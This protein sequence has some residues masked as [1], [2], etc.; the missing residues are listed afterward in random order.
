MAGIKLWRFNNNIICQEQLKLTHERWVVF[1]FELEFKQLISLPIY[2]WL[3]LFALKY[4]PTCMQSN[5]G[6]FLPEV[7]SHPCYK[8]SLLVRYCAVLFNL[9]SP[10]LT[11]R[12]C[13]N[14]TLNYLPSFKGNVNFCFYGTLTGYFALSIFIWNKS[15]VMDKTW[16]FR[17]DLGL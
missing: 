15:K 9:S 4:N 6:Q 5:L 7:V 10:S 8:M 17:I 1:F 13:Q 16:I 3:L 2:G 11:H 14:G 12:P